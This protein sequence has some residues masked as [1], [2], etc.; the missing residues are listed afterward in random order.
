MGRR[1]PLTEE[2]A[3]LRYGIAF[4]PAK[5]KFVVNPKKY[6]YML[7][8]KGINVLSLLNQSMVDQALKEHKDG[9]LK[10]DVSIFFHT[11]NLVI[12]SRAQQFLYY[13]I[14]SYI[15]NRSK[16]SN[17][18]K[19]PET[20]VDTAVEENSLF[21]SKGFAHNLPDVSGTDADSSV[22]DSLFN[23]DRLAVEMSFADIAKTF[24]LHSYRSAK[25]LAQKAVWT[26]YNLS[27][28]W[29]EKK[30]TNE[31]ADGYVE[32][33]NYHAIRF[34]SELD[35]RYSKIYTKNRCFLNGWGTITVW[36]TPK[37]ASYLDKYAHMMWYP[38]ALY[39]ASPK[40][41]ANAFPFGLKLALHMRMS[42]VNHIN[43]LRLLESTPDIIPYTLLCNKGKVREKIIVPFERALNHLLDLRVI[44]N[45]FYYDPLL[46]EKLCPSLP[47]G[48]R[49]KKFITLDVYFNLNDYSIPKSIV[50]ANI[51]ALWAKEKEVVS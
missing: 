9:V 19:E 44:T 26:L 27:V 5:P 46:G 7:Q 51:Q 22:H 14:Q 15:K 16:K 24:G 40:Y 25:Q 29:S 17:V 30:I 10:N 42:R 3:C 33:N 43:V 2:E 11:D 32:D 12:H 48:F 34:L 4:I 50:S 39:K 45:W 18:V 35:V 8:G 47:K 49:Y 38:L 6:A 41:D 28:E 23:D 37:F 20:S 1:K 13:I 36:L 21:D 31:N